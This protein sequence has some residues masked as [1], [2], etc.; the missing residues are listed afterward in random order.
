MTNSQSRLAA[1]S[2]LSRLLAAAVLLAS[3][4]VMVGWA[5]ELDLLKT[6]LPGFVSMKFNTAICFALLALARILAA[7]APRVGLAAVSAAV[8]VASAVLAQYLT[9][10]D[11]GIDEALFTDSGETQALRPP[12]R[13]SPITAVSILLLGAADLL[14]RARLRSQDRTAQILL[15]IVALVAFQAL[16]AYS[17]G[18]E[19]AVGIGAYTRIAIHTA[20][21]LFLL[22]MAGLFAAANRAYMKRLLAD[23][24]SNRGTIRLMIAAIL[25]PPFVNLLDRLGQHLGLLEPDYGALFRVITSVTFFVVIIWSNSVRIERSDLQVKRSMRTRR[26]ALAASRFKSEF[27][28]SIS[29]EVRTPL[30]AMIGSLELLARTSLDARQRELAADIESSARSLMTLGDRVLQVSSAD[31][32]DV[33]LESSSFNLDGLLSGTAGLIAGPARRKN[34]TLRYEV[35]P[36]TPRAFIG[37]SSRL[38]QVLLRLVN[39]ALAVAESG[40][41]T[42]KV[43]A[44]NLDANTSRVEFEIPDTGA[45]PASGS[46]LRRFRRLQNKGHSSDPEGVELELATAKGLVELMGGRIGA[47][48][49]PSGGVRLFFDVPLRRPSEA[50]AA[51][52][53]TAPPTVARI[54]VIDDIQVNQKIVAEML[55]ILGY[56]CQAVASGPAALEALRAGAFDL[57]LMDVHLPTMS[58]Y[59]IS[60]RIRAGEG[61]PQH[62]RVPIMAVTANSF[63]GAFEK[64][65]ASG[66]NDF[67]A[68]PFEFED[69]SRK[70]QK[71]I[72]RGQ[73][74]LNPEKIASLRRLA[75]ARS[76]DLMD[77]L[78]DLFHQEVPGLIRELSAAIGQGDLVTAAKT[79]HAIKSSSGSLGAFRMAELSDRIEH[80]PAETDLESMTILVKTLENEYVLV[81]DELH[82]QR[83]PPVS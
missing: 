77:R 20:L 7:R 13:F 70:I 61:G 26:R 58:G 27:M 48:E 12:G 11:L 31:S 49:A 33:I 78:I 42:V 24:P 9:G 65:L 69:F 21:G 35:E 43:R 74:V 16:V 52:I 50:A 18:I 37:D 4:V 57:V 55:E 83:T 60:H 53:P 67:I 6:V 75:Q 71:W 1:F 15:L 46:K 39:S 62:T 34:L 64:C 73:A 81:S 28:A 76:E 79:A 17:L 44:T 40:V 36:S 8:L 2:R 19:S 14:Q 41:I 10:M 72:L 30:N 45:G 68:K 32:N 66:M 25:F 63:H 56:H 23:T 3:L 51:A 59:E 38:Q 29:H 47:E 82:K 54:L 5:F 22:A 80:P